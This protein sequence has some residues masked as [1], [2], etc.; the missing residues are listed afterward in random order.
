MSPE[1]VGPG[2]VV[3]GEAGPRVAGGV[4]AGEGVE[5]AG[6]AGSMLPGRIG[7]RIRSVAVAPGFGPGVAGVGVAGD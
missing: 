6:V 3:D 5:V 2:E 1:A 7:F 4:S